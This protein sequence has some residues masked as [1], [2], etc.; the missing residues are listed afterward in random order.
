M[1]SRPPRSE[2]GRAAPIATRIT[3]TRPNRSPNTSEYS[4]RCPIR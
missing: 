3:R 4:R 2:Q 1:R